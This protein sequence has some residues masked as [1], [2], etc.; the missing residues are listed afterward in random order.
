VGSRFLGKVVDAPA[1]RKE[2]VALL[3]FLAAA[4]ANHKTLDF[5]SGFRAF[6]KRAI[7][8]IKINDDGYGACSEAIVS[9]IEAGLKVVE[10]PITIRYWEG[11]EA[12]AIARGAGLAG[13]IVGEIAK[14][15][16]LFYFGL[17]GT[18]L[19]ML[20]ALL[21]VFVVERF[22]ATKQLPIG[23][24]IL[25]VFSGIGGLVLILIGINLYTLGALLKRRDDD[26]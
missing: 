23:S 13:R 18:A 25:T 1:Y 12:S 11:Q 6:S 24:A 9:A 7:E 15:Q 5:Q 4:Q 17:G 21:G 8:K 22:Y 14:R 10:V 19:I 2:G 26:G 20:S 3:N 16:P